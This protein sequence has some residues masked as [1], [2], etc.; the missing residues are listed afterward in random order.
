MRPLLTRD[1]HLPKYYRYLFTCS[2]ANSKIQKHTAK[3]SQSAVSSMIT[4]SFRKS[5]ILDGDKR[6]G[7]VSPSRIRISVATDLANLSCVDRDAL[8]RCHMMHGKKTMLQYY[9]VVWNYRDGIRIA[10]LSQ[11]RYMDGKV[12]SDISGFFQDRLRSKACETSTSD[13]EHSEHNLRSNK[14]QEH[15]ISATDNKATNSRKRKLLAPVS[16]ETKK[17]KLETTAEEFDSMDWYAGREYSKSLVLIILA[18]A[19]ELLVG[20]IKVSK[21]PFY[22]QVSRRLGINNDHSQELYSTPWNTIRNILR[23]MQKKYKSESGERKAFHLMVEK[24]D[25]WFLERKFL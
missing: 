16:S 10:G 5:K 24:A 4:S 13:E 3:I 22:D 6:S 19:K 23:Y 12:Q 18:I 20:D 17:N 11:D 8:A 21:E 25:A 9:E 7:S 14:V 15:A 1:D 2:D